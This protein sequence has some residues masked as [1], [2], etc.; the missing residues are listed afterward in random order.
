MRLGRMWRG[1]LAV[2]ICA[3][4]TQTA[5]A[6]SS[7]DRFPF[8][9]VADGYRYPET[10]MDA[11]PVTRRP[12]PPA[13]ASVSHAHRRAAT[14]AV[15]FPRPAPRRDRTG[16]SLVAASE[17]SVVEAQAAPTLAADGAPAEL[18][19]TK[20]EAAQAVALSEAATPSEVAATVAT[21]V[22]SEGR[23]ATAIG[24]SIDEPSRKNA[25]AGQDLR[26]S[27]AP[28]R[29]ANAGPATQSGQSAAYAADSTSY[30]SPTAIATQQ[31]KTPFPA[32]GPAAT[33]AA[34]MAPLEA[35]YTTASL[36][37]NDPP[38]EPARAPAPAAAEG[39]GGPYVQ[40]PK[41]RPV[42]LGADD[43]V[44]L[45]ENTAVAHGIPLELAHAVVRIESNYNPGLTGRGGTLG[46][47]QI[48]YATARG[49]GYSG[50]AQ[51]LLDPTVNL[52]WGMRYLAGARKL[53]KG[54]LCGT[55]LRYQAGHRA[56][57]MTHAASQYC[58]RARHIMAGIR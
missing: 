31:I 19:A 4:G 43:I 11:A 56:V 42:K 14:A 47:M 24:A 5:V 41:Q 21:S 9:P 29:I 36:T 39:T 25:D 17:P 33:V 37:P 8:L 7:D 1:I 50:S 51:A 38:A 44:I 2:S 27:I 22:P 35:S 26:S 46:L 53:A 28:A 3:I 18:T 12:A 15:P 58:G 54:S 10:K 6:G 57:R 40:I 48:K 16:F 34:R 55:I 52:E 32:M 13:S 45:V 49:I 23:V 30:P 20:T